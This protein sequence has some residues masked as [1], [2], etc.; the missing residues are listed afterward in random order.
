MILTP[1][2]PDAWE[3]ISVILRHGDT[4]EL[5]RVG[6]QL[7]IVEIKRKIKYKMTPPT[8]EADG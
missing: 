8:G 4:V 5:K 3:T 6:G 1:F 7:Q 2:T